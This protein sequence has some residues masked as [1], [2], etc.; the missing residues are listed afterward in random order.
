MKEDAPPSLGLT[1]RSRLATVSSA[2]KAIGTAIVATLILGC[3]SSSSER[4][5]APRTATDPPKPVAT[6]AATTAPAPAPA[7][8]SPGAMTAA[9]AAQKAHEE[10]VRTHK[11]G[12][13]AQR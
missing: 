2:M 7:P 12:S 3:A 4:Q 5:P 9:E 11:G 8:A 6:S 1:M 10:W 13:A